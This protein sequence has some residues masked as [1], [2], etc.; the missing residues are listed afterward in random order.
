MV[1]ELIK[2]LSRDGIYLIGISLFTGIIFLMLKYPPVIPVP[3]DGNI[4]PVYPSYPSLEHE[5]RIYL[6]E[7]YLEYRRSA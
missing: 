6:E 2:S 7:R 3:V 1:K 5:H 4:P